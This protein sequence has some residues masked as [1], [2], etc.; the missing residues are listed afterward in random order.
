MFAGRSTTSFR[1]KAWSTRISQARNAGYS[2]AEM[3]AL[4][5]T[6]VPSTTSFSPA[7]RTVMVSEPKAE[8]STVSAGSSATPQPAGSA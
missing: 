6:S 3:R 8:R 2:L 4:D 7:R 1:E 5:I